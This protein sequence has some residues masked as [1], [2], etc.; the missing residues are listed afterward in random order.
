MIVDANNSSIGIEVIGGSE[1]EDSDIAAGLY[2]KFDMGDV[3]GDVADRVIPGN[4]GLSQYPAKL[5][6]SMSLLY[7]TDQHNWIFKPGSELRFFPDWVVQPTAW[8]DYY[9]P[10]DNSN[11]D[12]EIK[13]LFG[14]TIPIGKQ[15]QL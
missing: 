11:L 5:Y 8:L 6:S 13:L 12:N 7:D 3:A 15:P 2:T 1:F 14:F 10:E 9:V 4:W